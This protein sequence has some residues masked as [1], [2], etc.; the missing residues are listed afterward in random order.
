MKSVFIFC[1]GLL[2]LTGC[3]QLARDESCVNFGAAD[4]CLQPSTGVP[5]YA[6]T[7]SVTLRHPRGVEKLIVSLEVDAAGVRM[8]GLTPFGRRLFSIRLDNGQAPVVASDVPVDARLV[9]AGL[10]F[11]DWPLERVQQA[12]RGAEARIAQQDREAQSPR[13]FRDGEQTLMTATC[14]GGARPICRRVRLRYPTLD[15]ELLIESLDAS[16]S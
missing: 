5:P 7:R 8:A 1:F 2:L 16:A 10:Q 9:L 11:A 14:E 3:A 13:S 6:A 4:Y 12:A 15:M